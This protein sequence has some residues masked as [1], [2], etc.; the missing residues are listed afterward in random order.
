MAVDS[1]SK[2]LSMLNFSSE[3][4]LL[5]D[6]S[7]TIG[8]GPRATLLDLYSGIAAGEVADPHPYKKIVSS[9]YI[10]KIDIPMG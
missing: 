7:G 9:D 2:R 8:A 6:P 10:R 5:P 4:L 3:H 1:R